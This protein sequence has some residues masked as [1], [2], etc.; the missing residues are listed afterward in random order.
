VAWLGVRIRLLGRIPRID[1][2]R[3]HFYMW[4]S[5]ISK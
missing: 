5:V 3:G 1:C 4:L 2:D